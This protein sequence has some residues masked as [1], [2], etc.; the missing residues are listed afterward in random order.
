MK[1]ITPKL[2]IFDGSSFLNEKEAATS[3]STA[4]YLVGADSN[5]VKIF[6]AASRI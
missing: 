4:A 5:F 3:R 2:V 6:P 1:A